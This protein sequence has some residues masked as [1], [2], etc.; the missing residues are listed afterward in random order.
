MKSGFGT[1][2]NAIQ[3]KGHACGNKTTKPS[4]VKEQN[5][6]IEKRRGVTK[7]I[8]Q[9]SPTKQSFPYAPVS[10]CERI[11]TLNENARTAMQ[12]KTS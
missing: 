10:V 12:I 9:G 8:M 7:K 5:H 3:L 2:Y 6:T 11:K 4:N 1:K